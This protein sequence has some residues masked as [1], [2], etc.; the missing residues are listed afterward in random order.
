LSALRTPEAWKSGCAYPSFDL[1]T[2]RLKYIDSGAF[3]N[4]KA[5]ELV[6][7]P[8]SVIRI[9]PDAF[10]GC[11]NLIILCEYKSY[12]HEYAEEHDLEYVLY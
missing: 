6:K 7:I 10:D 3:R 8:S 12:A 9:A 5:L 2:A 11:E 4:C 1:S